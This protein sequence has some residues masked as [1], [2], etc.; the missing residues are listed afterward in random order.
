[1]NLFFSYKKRVNVYFSLLIIYSI[2]VIN[3]KIKG[4][5]IRDEDYSIYSLSLI[6]KI[7]SAKLNIKTAVHRFFLFV[8]LRY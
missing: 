2:P 7:I 5:K 8:Y 6:I 1:M 4:C 3:E